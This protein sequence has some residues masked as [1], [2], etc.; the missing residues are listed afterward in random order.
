LDLQVFGAETLKQA[1]CPIPAL[2]GKYT[3]LLTISKDLSDG[4]GP[5]I[6]DGEPVIMRIRSL[7]QA[8]EPEAFQHV[9]ELQDQL[10]LRGQRR[11]RQEVILDDSHFHEVQRSGEHGIRTLRSERDIPRVELCRVVQQ[12]R[13]EEFRVSV[14]PDMGGDHSDS[15][16][17][18]SDRL[19]WNRRNRMEA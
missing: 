16:A 6:T 18:L 9:R 10:V 17:V 4:Q 5:A 15:V 3:A 13:G 14:A 2:L 11:D 8:S 19:T 12:A 7:I 1:V